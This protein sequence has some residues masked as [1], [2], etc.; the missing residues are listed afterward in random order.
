MKNFWG[1]LAGIASTDWIVKSAAV[2][3]GQFQPGF[4]F[5][6]LPQLDYAAQKAGPDSES[7]L[8][9][10]V[11]LDEVLGQLVEG[12]TRA[13]G[14]Q[15]LTWVAASEYVITAVDHVSYPNRELRQAGL[16]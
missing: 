8:Q 10:V 9:A 14:A 13:Y 7:A 16:L 3:A 1:P 6:Y 15:E 4:F 12:F 11:E 2:A 5:L